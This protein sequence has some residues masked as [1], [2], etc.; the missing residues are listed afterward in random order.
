MDLPHRKTKIA[1]FRRVARLTSLDR[2]I[3][4]SMRATPRID[5]S[6]TPAR[7]PPF[8]MLS[9]GNRRRLHRTFRV[10]YRCSS[11]FGPRLGFPRRDERGAFRSAEIRVWMKGAR[12]HNAQRQ[13]ARTFPMCSRCVAYSSGYSSA[14]QRSGFDIRVQLDSRIILSKVSQQGRIRSKSQECHYRTSSR[15]T[16]VL[17]TCAL[18]FFVAFKVR[19]TD[20]KCRRL[21]KLFFSVFFF[22]F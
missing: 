8:V 7:Y 13:R 1:P 5:R 11:R 17:F 20:S 15:R 4:L 19:P 10:L 12:W 16:L 21:Y 6:R 9:K 2:D 22:F 18:F 14:S 3:D